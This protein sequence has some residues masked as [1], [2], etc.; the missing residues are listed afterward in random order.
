MHTEDA[1]HGGETSVRLNLNA[2]WREAM[3]FTE[4]ERA[5]LELAEQ[6]T[7]IADAAGGVTDETWAN[8]GNHYDEDRS[9]GL[10]SLIALI[11]A[12]DRMGVIIRR[13][14]QLRRRLHR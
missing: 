12:Y 11:K 3:V 6:V 14:V 10:M 7:R 2:T 8:A 5:A 4:A 9:A 1:M 13:P